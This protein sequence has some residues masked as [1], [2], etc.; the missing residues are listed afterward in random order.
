MNQEHLFPYCRLEMLDSYA[1][2]T[3]NEGVHIDFNE[4]QEI[5][6]VLQSTYHGQ[7]FGLI[8]NR[9]N[10]YSV[11]P[12]AI[13]KLFSD[14][15]LIAGAI[16]GSALMTKLNAEMEN[17]IIDDAPIGYFPS[18]NFAIKW[19]IKKVHTGHLILNC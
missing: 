19:I 4:I 7:K 15:Y 14:E 1:I 8:A 13:K 10:Q 17:D 3:C 16:V 11:N 6:S 9:E 18:M 2:V 12:L 5:E